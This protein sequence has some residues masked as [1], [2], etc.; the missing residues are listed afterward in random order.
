MIAHVVAHVFPAAFSLL[1]MEMN[2]PQARAM[3]I[4]IGLRESKFIYRRQI[5]FGPARGFWQFE[6]AGV[7]G[8]MHHDA[9]RD[10][11]LRVLRALRYDD[12][13]GK[14]ADVHVTLRDNDTLACCLAR[15][16]LWTVP[17]R[18]PNVGEPALGWAQYL[19]GWRPGAVLGSG[20]VEAA[21]RKPRPVEWDR[22]FT[23]GWVHA[24]TGEHP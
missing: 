3:L 21:L 5:S 19:E 8:V 11:V 7:R 9:T 23:T 10:D 1:P 12:S 16:L 20:T 6:K 15:L 13:I 4:A 24:I 18:L 2:T 14:T 17:G 22:Y